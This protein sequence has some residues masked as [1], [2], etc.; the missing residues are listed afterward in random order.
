MNFR[1]LIKNLK[2]NRHNFFFFLLAP[3]PSRDCSCKSVGDKTRAFLGRAHSYG[4]R[5]KKRRPRTRRVSYRRY[6]AGAEPTRPPPP[7]A[8][9]PGKSV[10]QPPPPPPEPL[11]SGR[12]PPKRFVFNGKTNDQWADGNNGQRAY[13]PPSC[14]RSCTRHPL[15]YH[16]NTVRNNN[17]NNVYRTQYQIVGSLCSFYFFGACEVCTKKKKTRN[18]TLEKRVRLR[19]LRI[20]RH[21]IDM[22]T[23]CRTVKKTKYVVELQKK[24]RGKNKYG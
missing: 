3:P 9:P 2:H 20:W 4:T 22:L 12:V 11:R 6:P 19:F 16:P 5:F 1:C 10:C 21:Y 8:A 7:D 15:C 24:K 23:A 13:P 18:T 14:D 17:N